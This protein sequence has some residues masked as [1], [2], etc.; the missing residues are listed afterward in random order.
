[1]SRRIP[2]LNPLHAFEAAARLGSFTRAA[3]ELQVT[4]SAVSRQVAVLEGYLKRRLFNR[5]HHGITLTTDGESYRREVAPAFAR[6]GTATRRLLDAAEV[7]PLRIRSYSTF[8]TRWLLPRLP[9]FHQHHPGIEVRLSTGIAPV[10]FMREE[11]DVAIQFGAGD[12]PGLDQQKLIAD[13]IQPVCSPK[14]LRRRNAPRTIEDLR[15][16]TLLHT[17]YRRNDWQD[18]LAAV[19]GPEIA[20]GGMVLPGSVLAYQAAME[21]LGIAMGQVPLLRS[22]I[23]TGVL[24]PLFDRPVERKLAHYAVWPARHPPDQRLRLFLAWLEREVGID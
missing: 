5:D 16:C 23:T 15:H 1:M 13:V 21:G 8:A 4:Q 3:Q 2:P 24:V 20:D 22:E 17:K 18:W 6:I 9:R 12:W 14:L 11:L 19:G 7:H 10:D